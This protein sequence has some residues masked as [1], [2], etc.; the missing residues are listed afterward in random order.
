MGPVSQP[1]GTTLNLRNMSPSGFIPLIAFSRF[2]YGESDTGVIT[3]L[4]NSATNL[5]A[6]A[7]AGVALLQ[8]FSKAISQTR[9]LSILSAVPESG[10]RSG[11]PLNVQTARSQSFTVTARLR[12]YDE[13]NEFAV[14]YAYPRFR[15]NS[16][17]DPDD[18]KKPA[19]RNQ[20]KFTTED[21]CR[22]ST[23]QRASTFDQPGS[24]VW[25]E[26]SAPGATH[27]W[28]SQRPNG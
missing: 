13:A 26:K 21:L 3:E 1:Q 9:T 18:L 22:L 14:T 5:G 25:V 8:H 11:Q 20:K 28:A 4:F 10:A 15:I 16:N 23:T 19:P 6:H 12:S 2:K 27:E 7:H 24:S 17:L